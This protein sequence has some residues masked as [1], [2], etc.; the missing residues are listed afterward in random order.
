MRGEAET[1]TE[2]GGAERWSE[3]EAGKLPGTA[4]SQI[5]EHRGPTDTMQLALQSYLLLTPPGDR[6]LS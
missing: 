4:K 3:W 2:T 6:C 1:E 5:A